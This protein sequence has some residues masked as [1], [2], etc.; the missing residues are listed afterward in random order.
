MSGFE[1]GR[2]DVPERQMQPDA[3][4]D[5]AVKHLTA[6]QKAKWKEMIGEE[7]PTICLLVASLEGHLFRLLIKMA[8]K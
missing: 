4:C 7:L 5:E 1:G 8:P 2:V 3:I 6:D